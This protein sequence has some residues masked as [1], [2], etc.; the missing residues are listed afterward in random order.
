MNED[1]VATPDPGRR[2]RRRSRPDVVGELRP[3]GDGLAAD[4]AGVVGKAGGRLEKDR[5]EVG[6]RDQRIGSR[7]LT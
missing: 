4:Q 2:Q 7:M 6:G 1:A 5:R 3:G